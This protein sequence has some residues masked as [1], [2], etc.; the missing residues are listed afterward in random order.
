MIFFFTILFIFV[1]EKES[2][3]VVKFNFISVSNI[4]IICILRKNNKKGKINY[5]L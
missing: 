1:H 4:V 2:S 5:M 3:N